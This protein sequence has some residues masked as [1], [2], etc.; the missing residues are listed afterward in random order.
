[1]SKIFTVVLFFSFYAKAINLPINP[2]AFVRAH[3]LSSDFNKKTRKVIKKQ[4]LRHVV[5][6]EVPLSRMD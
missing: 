6:L 4:K 5:E 3:L 2:K 1:M